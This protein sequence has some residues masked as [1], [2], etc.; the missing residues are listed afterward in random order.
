MKAAPWVLI[1]LATL[2]ATASASNLNG[3][4]RAWFVGGTSEIPK[5]SREIFFDFAASDD[6]LTG[7]AYMGSVA[8]ISE[9]KI[10]GDRFSFTVDGTTFAGTVEGKRITLST[11]ARLMRGEKVES[12]V[13]APVSVN[14]TAADV[15]GTWKA[16]FVGP[17]GDRPK[18]FSEIIFDFKVDGSG[19]TGNAHMGNWPGDAFIS[20]GRFEA[21]HF[22]FTATGRMPSSSGV[23]K[24]RIEGTIHGNEMK[25]T[26]TNAS[27]REGGG[28]VRSGPELPMD[29]RKLQ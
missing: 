19:L 5:P 15:T 2:D 14:A 12:K 29:G 9:G 1:L 4:W 16:W 13:V 23:P 26:M 3:T 10:D 8:S 6:K 18:M 11:D 21:G 17:M 22:S 27:D 28:L 20:D 7:M 25:V 24:F